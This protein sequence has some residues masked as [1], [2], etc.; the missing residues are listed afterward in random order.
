MKLIDKEPTPEMLAIIS[1]EKE[2]FDS[3]ESLYAALYEAAP[4]VKQEPVEINWPE[5]HCEAMGCGLEDRGITDRYDA[6][7][8]GWYEAIERCA[9]RIPEKLFELPTDAQAE[10]YKRDEL[11]TELRRGAYRLNEGWEVA[12]NEVIERDSIVEKQAAEITKLKDALLRISQV[13]GGI[14]TTSY[15]MRRIALAAIK[16]IEHAT[17]D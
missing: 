14:V 9:E 7:R 1:N 5:Y 4:E 6:M 16:E 17:T 12:S 11:I 8:Y 3:P 13:K 2:V 10:I 15:D